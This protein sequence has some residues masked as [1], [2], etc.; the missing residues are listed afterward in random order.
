MSFAYWIC[1]QSSESLS[2]SSSSYNFCLLKGVLIVDRPQL[3][4]FLHE[5]TR[6]I[7]KHLITPW[8]HPYMH[9]WPLHGFHSRYYCVWNQISLR[10]AARVNGWSWSVWRGT[11][12]GIHLKIYLHS[13]KA[14]SRLVTGAFRKGPLSSSLLREKNPFQLFFEQILCMYI[15]YK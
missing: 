11:F 14:R 4:L 10:N 5:K 1:S 2:L 15:H 12:T 7:R 8:H 9:F 13:G 6:A 3:A